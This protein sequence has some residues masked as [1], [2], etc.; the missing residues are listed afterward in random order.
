[1]TGVLKDLTIRKATE[2]DFDSILNLA[3]QLY[4]TEQPFDRNIKDGYY[5]TVTGRKE[6]LK[7]IKS[8]KRIFLVAM[9][10]N[11]VVGY[12]NGYIYDKED[13]YIKKVA[14]LDQIS[15]DKNYKQKGIGTKL[16]DEF[17]NKVKK[18]GAEYIKLNAFE[19]NEP[20]IKLYGKKGF[21]KYSIFYMKK[22]D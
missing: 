8:R 15:V 16:I 10:K 3:S 13:V 6:L 22:V 7:S 11:N 18:K 21:D 12:V 1:M 17:T 5:Q 19:D 14:Y 9:I 4:K 20:A 2:N